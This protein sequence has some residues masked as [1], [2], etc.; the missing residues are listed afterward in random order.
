MPDRLFRRL[1]LVSVLFVAACAAPEVTQTIN[2]PYEEQNRAVHE[3]NKQVTRTVLKPLTAGA[4]SGDGKPGFVLKTVGN[5]AG[6]VDTPRM[7]VNDILQANPEDA[8][9]NTVRFLINTTFGIAGLFDPATAWGLPERPSDFGETLHVW[10]AAEGAYVE[11]P[12]K[13][14]STSRDTAGMFVDFFLNPLSTVVPAP[15]RYAIPASN[16]VADM[17]SLVEYSDSISEVLDSSAD[18]YAQA[19]LLYLQN[20][21]FQLGQSGPA[22]EEIDPFALDTE[23]F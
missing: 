14:P 10:G 16:I 6:N 4:G 20:R 13:G 5:F 9:H 7:I 23:G 2:D 15:E 11:L 3:F 22:E 17:T 8:A 21:R 19:R 12:I 18:S 1:L